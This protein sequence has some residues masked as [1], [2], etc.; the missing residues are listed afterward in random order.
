MKTTKSNK[1]KPTIRQRKAFEK[2][3]E[4]YGNVS[5]SMREVGYSKNT[6]KTPKTLTE[7]KG[8]KMLS[9]EY[10]PNHK[11]LIALSEDIEKKPQN[12]KAELELAFKIKGLLSND[13]QANVQINIASLIDKYREE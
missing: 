8:F 7:S 11:L 3:M 12:R 1:I 10:L 6:A 5:K 13:N 9:E 2:T 4:N